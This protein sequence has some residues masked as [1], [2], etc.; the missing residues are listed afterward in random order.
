MINNSTILINKLSIG[1]NITFNPK[2]WFS[3]MIINTVCIT[4]EA[5]PDITKGPAIWKSNPRLWNKETPIRPII[6]Y[7]KK[8]YIVPLVDKLVVIN[9]NTEPAVRPMRVLLNIDKTTI[10]DKN[11]QLDAGAKIIPTETAKQ[12]I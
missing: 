4:T 2:G 6:K 8:I 5:I 12:I 7:K 11:T 10:I 9:S 1:K 3:K